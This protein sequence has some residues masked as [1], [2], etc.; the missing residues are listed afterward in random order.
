MQRFLLTMSVILRKSERH[1]SDLMEL[2]TR[3]NSATWL[4][5]A[6]VLRGWVRSA[7][8]NTAEGISWIEEGLKERGQPE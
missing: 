1:S 7:R 2:S 4:A 8:G 6:E 3:Q 5:H